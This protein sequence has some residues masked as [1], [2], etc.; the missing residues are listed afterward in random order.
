MM[1]FT[2]CYSACG[3]TFFIAELKRLIVASTTNG[4]MAIVVYQRWN[5]FIHVNVLRMSQEFQIIIKLLT[6]L[7]F[8]NLIYF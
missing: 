1:V 8:C 3:K 6:Q 7:C 4:W 5:F 2:Q